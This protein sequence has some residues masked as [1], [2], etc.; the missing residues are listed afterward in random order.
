MEKANQA[1]LISKDSSA[2]VRDTTASCNEILKVLQTL[3][4]VGT[5]NKR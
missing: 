1:K 2:K 4:P 5:N 3:E